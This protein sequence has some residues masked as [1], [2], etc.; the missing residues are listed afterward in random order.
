MNSHS[1]IFHAK[2]RINIWVQLGQ[3]QTK[4]CPV[5]MVLLYTWHMNVLN[6]CVCLFSRKFR[7][8]VVQYSQV[9][10]SRPSDTIWC[11]RTGSTL[12][13]L[14]TCYSLSQATSHYLNQCWHI[15]REVQWQ[16]AEANFT[17][18]VHQQSIFKITLKITCL[19]FHSNLP[20]VN[21]LMFVNFHISDVSLCFIFS[22]SS[23]ISPHVC[24]A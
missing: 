7:V 12:A 17:R 11:H 22:V 9:N 24:T 1:A 18:H 5:G 20:G 10:S 21:E 2:P 8:S 15:I 14:M 23:V 16:S 13:Q 6:L 4:G 19:K 3:Y